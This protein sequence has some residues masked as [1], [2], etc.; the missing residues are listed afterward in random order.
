MGCCFYDLCSP[1][2]EICG[3]HGPGEQS[4]SPRFDKHSLIARH[5]GQTSEELWKGVMRSRQQEPEVEGW[6]AE[7]AAGSSLAHLSLAQALSCLLRGGGDRPHI[8]A[9]GCVYCHGSLQ[10]ARMSLCHQLLKLKKMS[11]GDW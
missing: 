7:W 11:E 1:R 9:M 8:T 3:K 2:R 4:Q 5:W 6:R 10:Y